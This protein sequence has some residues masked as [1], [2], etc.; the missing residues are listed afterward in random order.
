M[1]EQ[2]CRQ[3]QRDEWEVLESIYPDCISSDL[4]ENWAFK[5]EVPIELADP[6]IVEVHNAETSRTLTLSNLPPLLLDVTLPASYPLE[7]PPR[8]TSMQSADQWYMQPPR[9]LEDLTQM[10]EPGSQVLYSWIEYIRGGQ[11]LTEGRENTPISLRHPAPDILADLLAAYN[12][13]SSRQQFSQNSYAC[14]IC[15]THHKGSKCIQLSCQ[16]IFGRSCL[17]DYWC[18]L[19]TE[20]DIARVRCPDQACMKDGVEAREEEVALVLKPDEITRWKWLQEKQEMEKDPAVV[21]C[22]MKYCQKL[23]PKPPMVN[24][25]SGWVRLRVC[26]ACSYSFCATCKHGWHGPISPCIASA[27]NELVQQYLATTEGSME[28]EM[29][30]RQYGRSYVEKLLKR[31]EEEQANNKL[32]ESST[33]ACPGCS[34]RVEKSMGCNHMTCFKC[35]QHFCYRCGYK[36]QPSNPYLHFNTPGLACFQRLFDVGSVND[37]DGWILDLQLEDDDQWE[38]R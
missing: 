11:F 4:D 12:T 15:M 36:L 18:S 31:W 19:V 30:L 7:T 8:V 24:D 22:P 14:S 32:L 35:K 9:L 23:V 13:D 28:R 2:E 6:R 26:S 34:V 37:D 10:W 38:H 16:H 17:R 20:G 27:T 3:Q 29:L 25:D 33:T 5:L 21:I 1:T